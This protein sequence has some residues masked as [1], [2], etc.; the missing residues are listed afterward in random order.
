VSIFSL[1][2]L[3]DIR[4]LSIIQ[5]SISEITDL[6]FSGYDSEGVLLI[7]SPNGDKLTAQ[8]KTC[9]SVREKYEEFIRNGVV[10][11]FVRK[12]PSILEGPASEH[13]LF[14]PVDFDNIKL[15]FVSN[16]FYFTRTK[17]EEFLVK[18]RDHLGLST[19]HL[20][21]WLEMIKV[22][23]YQTIQEMGVDIKCLFESFL[24][25][26]Y[27]KNLNI[28]NY[29]RIKTLADILLSIQLPASMEKVYSLVLDVILLLFDVDSVSIMV[30][31]KNFFKTIMASGRLRNE[32]RFLCVEDSNPVIS[33]SIKDCISVFTNSVLEIHRLGLSDNIKS[34]QVFHLSRSGTI[35]GAVV[36]YNPRILEEESRCIFEFCRLTSLILENL[37]FQNA[38]R[39]YVND[40]GALNM[41]VTELI[42]YLCNQNA[43]YESI[44]NKAMELLKAEKGSFMLPEDDYLVVKA[45]K[46]VHERLV[47]GIK[48]KI[49]E[50]IA[51]KVFKDGNP[52][53]VE[54]IEEIRSYFRYK[55][56][57]KADSFICVP[58]K[59]GSETMGVL[60][61]S[62]KGTGEKFTEGD[63][64]L[65]NQFASC[66]SITLKASNYY[67]LAE[68]M[69]EFAIT[70]PLTGLF[71]RRYFHKRFTEEIQRSE[72]YKTVFSLAIIDID[73]F[74]LFNETEGQPAGDSALKEVA[75]IAHECIRV[76]DILSRFGGEKFA[77]LMPQTGQE[78]AFVVA[79]RIREN[80][81][82]SFMHRW[83]KFPHPSITV[84]IGI[85]SFPD[86]GKSIDELTESADAALYKAKSMGKDRTIILSL[87]NDGIQNATIS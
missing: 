14:I 29:K 13:H 16:A 70:E 24:R 34:M 50:G 27:D 56:H 44:L 67:T 87:F 23:D 1:N 77:I 10:K 86:N 18:N 41:A 52:L 84:S 80:I 61:I 8:I 45:V 37:I 54:D 15:V 81:K 17:F 82:G 12:D 22:K 47:K 6:S 40:M 53:L 9:P 28:K 66:A 62:D 5:D 39:K 38:C 71:N 60:N 26:S 83:K 64:N 3:I 35:Y 20:E 46:G 57:Y 31:E 79:E 21:S 63:L 59:S 36:I 25:Y 11:A 7:P 72:L 48:V 42:L 65:V 85:A 68:Q 69:K 33:Q 19:I 43:L 51:G 73:N 32:I 74:R 78:K 30:K 76:Y 49:G 75:R 4:L 2:K 55:S 58:L